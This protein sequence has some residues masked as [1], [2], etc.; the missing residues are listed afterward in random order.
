MQDFSRGKGEDPD[1]SELRR[2]Q[3]LGNEY[4]NFSAPLSAWMLNLKIVIYHQFK[5]HLR[6]V[7][8][9]EFALNSFSHR[10]AHGTG[11]NRGENRPLESTTKYAHH[12]YDFID[13][14]LLGEELSLGT[15]S[16][17]GEV[18][19][20][21]WDGQLAASEACIAAEVNPDQRVR[22]LPVEASLKRCGRSPEPPVQ[23]DF[24]FHRIAEL[25]AE[26]LIQ[27]LGKLEGNPLTRRQPTG[28]VGLAVPLP[29]AKRRQFDF[30]SCRTGEGAKYPAL[31]CRLLTMSGRVFLPPHQGR[32]DSDC[33]H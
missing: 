29:R 10:I 1:T 23:L 20:D 9:D 21:G 28:N 5:G 25:P 31:A 6:P 27:D 32:I 3:T 7:R 12:T 14:P 13:A 30:I 18:V 17:S 11:T 24:Q 22:V 19:Q 16:Q 4:T 2:Y 15:W 8:L 33:L 26:A